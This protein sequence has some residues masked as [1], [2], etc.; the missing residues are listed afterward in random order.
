[1]R[2]LGRRGARQVRRSQYRLRFEA[3]TDSDE[4][5]DMVRSDWSTQLLVV[6]YLIP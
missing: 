1:M 5:A 3:E 4:L 2:V 6:N